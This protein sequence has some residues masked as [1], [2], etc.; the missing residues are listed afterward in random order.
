MS[1]HWRDARFAVLA[2]LITLAGCATTPRDA[3][4]SPVED[5]RPAPV[6][7]QHGVRESAPQGAR[8]SAPA[9]LEPSVAEPLAPPSAQPPPQAMGTSAAVVALL[10][11]ADRE[12]QG[13]NRGGA[14]ARLERA[15][16]LEPRNALLW[17]RLAAL[18]MEQGQ[19]RMGLQLAARSNV[20]AGSDDRLR[21]RN[22]RLIASGRARVGD[23][24][25]ARRARAKVA[26]LQARNR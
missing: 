25:G 5:R 11:D 4:P 14:A 15:L 17:H 22:W 20:L 9:I 24:A 10:R 26:E 1:L 13:G 23:L 6:Q 7:A 2:G 21:L 3:P 16:R 8:P 19:L 18:R 12:L